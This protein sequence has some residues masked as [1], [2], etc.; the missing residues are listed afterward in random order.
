MRQRRV[1][2][3]DVHRPPSF[4]S[5][6][7]A[8]T[9]LA[10]KPEPDSDQAFHPR[11]DKLARRDTFANV[12]LLFGRLIGCETV[13][14]IAAHGERREERRRI[15]HPLASAAERLLGSRRATTAVKMINCT[16]TCGRRA[17]GTD[18]GIRDHLLFCILALRERIDV[19]YDHL[20]DLAACRA[21]QKSRVAA[22]PRYQ[23]R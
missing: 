12:T 23:H 16:T 11:L 14:L 2:D 1:C 4:Y 9:R 7:L 18:I 22:S 15:A 20:Q 17:R 5:S 13:L 3:S 19:R 10:I 21:S 6:S 8:E